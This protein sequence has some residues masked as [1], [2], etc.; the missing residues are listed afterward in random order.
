MVA[1][2]NFQV[3][4]PHLHCQIFAIQSTEKIVIMCKKNE[5]LFTKNCNFIK[6]KLFSFLQ[7]SQDKTLLVKK[8]FSSAPSSII[9]GI[10]PICD[11][12]MAQKE[13]V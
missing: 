4:S 9:N 13:E 3:L 1:L 5:D 12:E 8:E 7:A 6:K 2:K 10:H 11:K